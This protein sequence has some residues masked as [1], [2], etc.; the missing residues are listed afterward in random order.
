MRK[1]LEGGSK[2]RYIDDGASLIPYTYYIR[3]HACT[4]KQVNET[5]EHARRIIARKYISVGQENGIQFDIEGIFFLSMK[6]GFIN[7]AKK[8]L[9]IFQVNVKLFTYFQF[10]TR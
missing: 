2:D 5:L 7:F 1:I 8:K 6:I 3:T 10:I 9:F 4:Q